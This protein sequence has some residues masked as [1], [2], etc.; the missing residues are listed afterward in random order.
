MAADRTRR[1]RRLRAF[2][3]NPVAMRHFERLALGFLLGIVTGAVF[4]AAQAQTPMN[5]C[6]RAKVAELDDLISPADV[7]ARAVN[8]QCRYLVPP[9]TVDPSS[10]DWQVVENLREKIIAAGIENVIIPEVLR[11][12]AAVRRRG[13]R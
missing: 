11:Y 4:Y 13:T 1:D 12:R 3:V 8:S 9:N 5:A 2:I 10:S 6:V 7:I